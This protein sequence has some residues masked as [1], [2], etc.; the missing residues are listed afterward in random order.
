MKRRNQIILFLLTWFIVNTSLAQ[1]HKGYVIDGQ[2]ANLG[3]GIKVY[4]IRTNGNG[5]AD[6]VSTTVSNKQHFI[7][8]GDLEKEGELYFVKLDTSKNKL[9][10]NRQSWIR[11]FL[12]NSNIKI[13]GNLKDWPNVSFEGSPSTLQFDTLTNLVAK[14]SDEAGKVILSL[15]NDTEKIVEEKKRYKN[16]LNELFSN[17]KKSFATPMA[18]INAYADTS[19][20]EGIYASLSTRVKESF[21]GQKLIE[22]V[23]NLKLQARIKLG[24][25]IPSFELHTANGKVIS[26]LDE[27]NKAKFTL[28]DFWASWCKPCREDVPN[29]LKVFNKFHE[30]GFNIISISSDDNMDAWE[31]VMKDINAPWIQAIEKEVQIGK[32]IFGL[33]SIPGYLLIDNKGKMVAFYR[34]FGTVPAF[35]PELREQLY[36]TIENLLENTPKEIEK[37]SK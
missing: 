32:E 27:A 29:L 24:A 35:G 26:I 37:G 6:T 12:E 36:K 22:F 14:Y 3:N 11:L 15:G 34:G 25:T 20:L 7:F 28:L 8:S 19:F 31:K 17:Y 10:P 1:K 4:L 23:Q 18:A 21:Y 2:I 30:Q 13:K 5:G 9:Q 16:L 33:N